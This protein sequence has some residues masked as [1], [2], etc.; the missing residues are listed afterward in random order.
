MKASSRYAAQYMMMFGMRWS[1]S[2][3]II[4]GMSEV[5]DCRQFSGTIVLHSSEF[6]ESFADASEH[7]LT[8]LHLIYWASPA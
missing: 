4:L 6:K 2:D 3:V 5:V 8:P 1:Y 7:K